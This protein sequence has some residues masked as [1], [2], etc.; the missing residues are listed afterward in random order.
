MHEKKVALVTGSNK[1]IGH[2][3]GRQLGK[4][5]FTV[6]LAARDESKVN[7][8]ADRLRGEGLDVPGVV[9]TS[10][11]LPPPRMPPDGSTGVSVASTC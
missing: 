11:T 2:E 10:P 7:A 9:W 4:L 5:G 8:A 3:I 6:V 1:G